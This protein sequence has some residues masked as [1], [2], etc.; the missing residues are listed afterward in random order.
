MK[1]HAVSMD[2]AKLLHEMVEARSTFL[3]VWMK[4]AITNHRDA[5]RLH[6]RRLAAE[7]LIELMVA[8]IDYENH[9]AL[10]FLMRGYA[11]IQQQQAIDP[12]KLTQEVEQDLDEEWRRIEYLLGGIEKADHWRENNRYLSNKDEERLI[13]LFRS[14]VSCVHP[15]LMSHDELDSC[16]FFAKALF[17]FENGDVDEM[18]KLAAHFADNPPKLLPPETDQEIKYHILVLRAATDEFLEREKK[19][20]TN[21]PF[22]SQALLDDPDELDTFISV[23]IMLH[24]DKARQNWIYL[25]QMEQLVQMSNEF[26]EVPVTA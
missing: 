8:R 5:N 24:E 21:Y 23:M 22:T 11:L 9:F 2:R 26:L 3:D 16:V 12:E 17:S 15:H 25:N 4:W 18:E 1:I 13:S 20:R 7:G 6:A 10:E 14:V 19:D